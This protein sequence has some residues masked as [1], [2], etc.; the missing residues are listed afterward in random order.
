VEDAIKGAIVKSFNETTVMLAEAISGSEWEFVQLMNKK[1]QKLGME[2]TN[3]RNATGLHESGQ[4]T[5]SYDLARLV[6]A[7]RRDFPEYYHFFATKEIE[8]GGMKYKSH[9]TILFEYP[10]SEGLKTGFTN[11]AGYNLIAAA[12]KN[13][14]RV[15]SI[16]M[17]CANI[18]ARDEFTKQLLDK[19]FLEMPESDKKVKIAVTKKELKNVETQN[20]G[21]DKLF[22]IEI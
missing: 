8:I 20:A 4:F 12:K 18:K 22:E 10:G 15:I 6:L 21:R 5:N 2:Y 17:S 14:H 9:N 19:A 11:A 16:L 13:D 1:A 7:L 3:F